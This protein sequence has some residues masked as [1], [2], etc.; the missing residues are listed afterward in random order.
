[1]LNL[2]GCVIIKDGFAVV[3]SQHV[4]PSSLV[5]L[6]DVG[7]QFP[8]RPKP[9]AFL[10]IGPYAIVSICGQVK[11]TVDLMVNP[12]VSMIEVKAEPA[13]FPPT[14]GHFFG[15]LLEEGKSFDLRVAARM[16]IEEDLNPS[17]RSLG[18]ASLGLRKGTDVVSTSA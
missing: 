9:P 3:D 10:I 5:C 17:N 16:R 11:V 6:V 13:T 4:Q 12:P 1:M 2:T 8:G 18:N 15:P 7:V 14:T